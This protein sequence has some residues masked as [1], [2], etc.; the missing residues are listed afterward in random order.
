MHC[1]HIAQ[2]NRT[3][4]KMPKRKSASTADGS[5][6]VK[7]FKCKDCNY[8]SDIKSNL[9]AHEKTH[10]D[11]NL[12]SCEICS[13]TF[14]NKYVL[15]RHMNRHSKLVEFKCTICASVFPRKDSCDYHEQQCVKQTDKLAALQT[16]SQRKTNECLEKF[17][18]IHDNVKSWLATKVSMLKVLRP[19]SIPTNACMTENQLEQAKLLQAEIHNE[20]KQLQNLAEIGRAVLKEKSP[21]REAV[22]EK[23]QEIVKTWT[24]LNDQVQ[25]RIEALRKINTNIY[26]V[27]DSNVFMH[28]LTSLRESLSKGKF[29]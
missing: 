23:L 5:G 22:I 26:A 27:V 12:L 20:H 3:D 14:V 19:I 11:R 18:A 6:T 4:I 10:S 1:T 8:E 16:D 24:N 7:K 15:A 13:Q 2:P 17:L 28:N 9:K 29:I 25:S 21:E